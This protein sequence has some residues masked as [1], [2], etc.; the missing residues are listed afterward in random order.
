MDNQIKAVVFDLGNVLIPFN[1][2]I[3]VDKLN[4]ID[5]GLG[6]RFRAR[7]EDNYH[8]HQRYETW[9]VST[10]DFTR[11]LMDWTEYKVEP[12]ELLKI[13]SEIFTF[14]EDVIA[15][16]PKIKENYKLYL[17]SNTN[18]I[19]KEYGYRNYGFFEHFDK[20]FLSHEVGYRKPQKEVYQ[21]VQNYN[22]FLPGEHIFIDDVLEY[23]EGA[24]S[25]GWNGI[26]FT[27]YNNLLEELAK[28]K[29]Q[30]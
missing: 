4:N 11:M 21:F 23:V 3:T 6:N 27:G 10:E 18:Y 7:Y 16:L 28:Y 5:S 2:L 20:L 12:E 8:L 13:Y 26:Q 9:S 24:K 22:G 1:Y 14:N 30:C 25:C 17:L 15:L 19:H 29:I